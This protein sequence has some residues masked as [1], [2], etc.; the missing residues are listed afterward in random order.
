MNLLKWFT[1]SLAWLN[2]IGGQFG[3][4]KASAMLQEPFRSNAPHHD[5][6]IHSE[7]LS[8]FSAASWRDSRRGSGSPAFEFRVSCCPRGTS[9]PRANQWT[10]AQAPLPRQGGRRAAGLGR[11]RRRTARAAGRRIAV[12]HGSA[13]RG[14]RAPTRSGEPLRR[15]RPRAHLSSLARGRRPAKGRRRMCN[16]RS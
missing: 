2:Q 5:V 6:T 3:A 16:C 14:R 12:A 9:D 8:Y 1:E 11:R 15:L 10:R 4:T 13:R 7:S